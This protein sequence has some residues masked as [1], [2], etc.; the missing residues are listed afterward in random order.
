MMATLCNSVACA[1]SLQASPS[2]LGCFGWFKDAS[3]PPDDYE[4]TALLF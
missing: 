3:L 2:P 4:T 1:P